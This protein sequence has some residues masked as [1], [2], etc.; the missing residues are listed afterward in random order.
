MYFIHYFSYTQSIYLWIN[1]GTIIKLWRMNKAIILS[2]STC[3]NPFI[4]SHIL[5]LESTASLRNEIKF[6]FCDSLFSL[7]HMFSF[8]LKISCLAMG[9]ALRYYMMWSCCIIHQLTHM[10]TIKCWL[11]SFA[12]FDELFL[13]NVT[14]LRFGHNMWAYICQKLLALLFLAWWQ[15]YGCAY[16]Y[17]VGNNRISQVKSAMALLQ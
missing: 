7:Y 15:R 11:M 4:P 10:W 3:F 1:K 5:L 17:W 13:Q 9:Q 2:R 6:S 12:G 16:D 14:F 8:K